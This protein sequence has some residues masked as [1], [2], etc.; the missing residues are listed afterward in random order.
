MIIEGELKQYRVVALATG[1]KGLEIRL[2]APSNEI[3]QVNMNELDN[4]MLKPLKITLED[5]EKI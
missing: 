3:Y 2:Y 4:L 1:D 5:M